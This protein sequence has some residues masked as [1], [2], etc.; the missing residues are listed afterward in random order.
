M[1]M[2][3]PRPWGRW[4]SGSRPN[5]WPRVPGWY[6]SLGWRPRSVRPPRARPPGASRPVT[7]APPRTPRPCAPGPG[8][9]AAQAG[10]ARGPM[11]HSGVAGEA[12][13]WVARQVSRDAVVG[14]DPDMCPLLRA[15]GFPA[16]GLLVLGPGPVGLRFCDV[17]VATKAV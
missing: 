14:C 4:G 13:P 9:K 10:M 2:D 8:E 6:R 5:T 12:A 3:Q 7:L 16:G 1:F 17:I 11:G 15:N